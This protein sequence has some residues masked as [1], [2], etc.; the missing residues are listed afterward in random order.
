MGTGGLRVQVRGAD[1]SLVLAQCDEC[2]GVGGAVDFFLA[3]A[4]DDDA[5]ALVVQDLYLD[6]R[7]RGDDK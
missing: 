3:E 2:Q 1:V 4:L 6:I 7:G 5:A